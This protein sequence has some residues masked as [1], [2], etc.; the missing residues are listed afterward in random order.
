MWGWDDWSKKRLMIQREQFQQAGRFRLRPAKVLGLIHLTGKKRSAA[1]AQPLAY[2][3]QADQYEGRLFNTEAGHIFGLRLGGVNESENVV[4]MFAHV[5]RRDFRELERQVEARYTAG[6]SHGLCISLVYGDADEPR[7]PTQINVQMLRDMAIRDDGTFDGH[8]VYSTGI[9]QDVPV[10]TRIAIDAHMQ[11]AFEQ[12]R[13]KV[14]SGWCLEQVG[15]VNSA[16]LPPKERRP[17]AFLDYLIFNPS[18][19]V[20]MEGIGQVARFQK[21]S[22]AQRSLVA[23]A[24]RYSQQGARLGECWSDESDDPVKTAL[25]DLGS[26]SGVEIDHIV[27]MSRGGYNAFSNAQVTSRKFNGSKN[28]NI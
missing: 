4:P 19:S 18:D 25:L 22:K 11:A 28:N 6:S 12:A 23:L 21:F 26:D 14:A 7:M 3:F 24:N 13:S 2:N 8:T 17:Y 27:P 5:N 20:P 10:V 16:G 1:N 9:R 15:N